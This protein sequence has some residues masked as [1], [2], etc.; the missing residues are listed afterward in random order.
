[1]PTATTTHEVCGGLF[2]RA[3]PATTLP[4]GAYV[5]LADD[6]ADNEDRP[7]MVAADEPEP[8]LWRFACL[9][10]H[11]DDGATM[12]F[13]APDETLELLVSYEA[14]IRR[15]LGDQEHERWDDVPF[16]EPA[17]AAPAVLSGRV[18]HTLPIGATIAD[19]AKTPWT[20]T[21]EKVWEDDRGNQCNNAAMDEALAGGAEVVTRAVELETD[22]A[23]AS[24]LEAGEYVVLPFGW[25]SEVVGD[26]M[27]NYRQPYVS[28]Q[29]WRVAGWINTD[30]RYMTVLLDAPE[31]LLQ[32]VNHLD[33]VEGSWETRAMER[34]V[35]PDEVLRVVRPGQKHD[36]WDDVY[37]WN[38]EFTIIGP[39]V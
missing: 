39:P 26:T 13:D 28:E 38:Y 7:L 17:P 12:L 30:E 10:G 8:V 29:L 18:C 24:S 35:K 19:G 22:P 34:W 27:A 4:V 21:Q 3:V 23:E 6:V 25:W 16:A 11:H 20:K 1:M 2:S 32:W 37:D 9:V 5:L 15:V 14:Q 31:D 33:C 36:R